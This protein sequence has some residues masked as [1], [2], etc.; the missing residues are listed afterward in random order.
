MKVNNPSDVGGI[1]SIP[2]QGGH[3]PVGLNGWEMTGVNDYNSGKYDVSLIKNGTPGTAGGNAGAGGTGGLGGNAGGIEIISLSNTSLKYTTKA[4]AGDPGDP[5]SHG[6]VGRG[7]KNGKNAKGLWHIGGNP[8][9]GWNGHPHEH[10]NPGLKGERT[11]AANGVPAQALNTANP[12]PVTAFHSMS[13]P[14]LST[15]AAT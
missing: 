9:W 5:G 13:M 1:A 3:L 7:G 11:P 10:P 8:D 14:R 2:I 4:K 15:T 12:T 6:G